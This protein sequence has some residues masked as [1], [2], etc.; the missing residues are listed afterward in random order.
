MKTYKE[1]LDEKVLPNSSGHRNTLTDNL[2]KDGSSLVPNIVNFK[3]LNRMEII[4]V[5]SLMLDSINQEYMK[6]HNGLTLW[7][8]ASVIKKLS[9]M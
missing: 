8:T 1:F 6:Q 3:T 4:T 7:G 5:V 2:A 9:S